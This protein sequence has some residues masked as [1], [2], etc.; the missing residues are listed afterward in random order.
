VEP[1]EQV[2]AQT[3]ALYDY[4]YHQA[5]AEALSLLDDTQVS[6]LYCEWHDDYVTETAPDSRYRFHQV[7]T[8]QKSQGPWRVG[9][10]FGLA[11]KQ[12]DPAKADSIFGRLWDHVLKFGGRCESFVFVTDAG[13]EAKFE[14]LLSQTGTARRVDDLPQT[15]RKTFDKIL[16][17][18]KPTFNISAD[19]LFAFLQRF[20]VQDGVGAVHDG[21]S[22]RVLIAV[23]IL[24]AS[25]VDLKVSEAEKIGADLVATVR[26]RSHRTL[27]ALPSTRDEL[28]A[29]KGI[30]ID[31]LLPLLSLSTEGYRELKAGGRESVRAL[32][33]LHRLCKRSNV[34]DSLIPDFCRYKTAWDAWW[35]D[36]RHRVDQADY[37]AIKQQCAVL[38]RAHAEAG[39]SL[40]ELIAQA[41]ALASK[42]GTQLASSQPLTAE[43]ILGFVFSLAAEAEA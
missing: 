25:E 27:K 24:E 43:L 18:V 9:E 5:A 33:R 2:G 1:R 12:S 14:D 3:G 35:I 23:R 42:Y 22:A 7:K 13:I 28:R 11:R 26:D 39:L 20:R 6:C 37:L 34:P 32:S 8:R 36:Q 16:A 19:E 10:F 41:K 21:K 38:L 17:G 31:N 29:S 4:Q 15:P 40:D 30:G